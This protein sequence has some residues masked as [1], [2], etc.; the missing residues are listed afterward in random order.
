MGKGLFQGKRDILSERQR[1]LEGQIAAL[2][3]E[4]QR[5]NA[6]GS[7]VRPL[8][9]GA[10]VFESANPESLATV[11]VAEQVHLNDLGGRKVDV[12][13]LWRR[14]KRRVFGEPASDPR[15]ISY[16][17]AG[18]I[19]GLRP[20]RHERRVARNR[21]ILW[22]LALFLLLWGLLAVILRNS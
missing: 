21:F 20:L 15:L 22:T 17:A 7:A 4:I 10:P 11:P 13:A 8:A 16:L 6:R 3:S 1:A 14:L 2:E 5:L 18:N 9:D 12:P 19:H